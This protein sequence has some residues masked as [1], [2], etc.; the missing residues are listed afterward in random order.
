MADDRK[1]LEELR[2]IDE[3]ERKA[4]GGKV[5]PAKADFSVPTKENLAEGER[6]AKARGASYARQQPGVVEQILASPEVP[7]SMVQNIPVS[8]AG[9]AVTG[10]KAEEMADF[11][12][13]Y[14]YQFKTRGGQAVAEKLGKVAESLPPALG[15]GGAIEGA[16]RTAAPAARQAAAIPAVQKAT[17]KAESLGKALRTGATY[18]LRRGAEAVVGKTTPSVESLAREREAMGY[19]FEPSQLREVQPLGSPGYDTKRMRQ[20]QTLANKEVTAA[21]GNEIGFGQIT[22]DHLDETKKQLGS[23]YDEIFGTEAKPKTLNIDETLANA[24]TKAAEFEA[25]I[26]PAKVSGIQKTADNLLRR[27]DE[28]QDLNR[29]LAAFRKKPVVPLSEP[30][31]LAAST[32]KYWTNLVEASAKNAPEFASEIQKTVDEL[33]KNLNLAVK[34]KVWFGNDKSGNTYGMANTDGHIVIRNGMDRDA[35]VATAMHEFGHQAEFQLLIHAP[36]NVQS[37]IY[38]AF[39]QHRKD[40][41]MGTKTVEQYRPITAAKYP[42][43]LRTGIPTRQFENEYLRN[44]SEWFAE[45]TSRWI[46]TTE[47]PTTVVEKFFANVSKVWKEIYQR[48][49][50]H[51]G[52]AKQVDDFFKSRWNPEM[53]QEAAQMQAPVQ[54]MPGGVNGRELQALRSNLSDLTYRLSGQDRY[55]AGQLLR[56]IDDAIERNNPEIAKLF[57]DTN[58]KYAANSLLLELEQKNGI[59]Q[60]NVSLE[61]LGE[62]TKYLPETHPLY[63]TG[64][65]GRQLYQRGM[66]EGAQLPPGD[67]TSLLTRGK[68]FA[69]GEI[70]DSPLAR[71][72]Q[73]KISEPPKE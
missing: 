27:W 13:K 43:D 24:A 23:K 30:P 38:K 47:K 67:L 5:S 17:S 2:R 46:T 10:G 29:K 64:L 18:P 60:G 70:T 72:M 37:E 54:A 51:V 53:I 6:Q 22:K 62:L 14:G 61:K 69:L 48:V 26:D 11:M 21:T 1:E 68:R 55:R 58:K 63:R 16:M 33:S 12:R 19:Q 45:Q 34:P 39:Q 3:L 8:L 7:I 25:A 42:E 73:R 32:R 44:F 9:T 56:E 31:P 57:K 49:T 50:G 71:W 35:A 52:L 36:S 28:I 20:N 4:A 66:F 65:A 41:R 59:L 15:M 40:V